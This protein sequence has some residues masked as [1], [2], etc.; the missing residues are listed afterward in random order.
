[1]KDDGVRCA[2]KQY[3]ADL[4]KKG[5]IREPEKRPE[6]KRRYNKKSECGDNV[7]NQVINTAQPPAQD[8][9]TF[10]PAEPKARPQAP[11]QVGF[12]PPPPKAPKGSYKE[13]SMFSAMEADPFYQRNPA[14]LAE[15][16]KNILSAIESKPADRPEFGRTASVKPVRPMQSD[17]QAPSV[18]RVI[19]GPEITG[20]EQPR[21]PV[22]DP[23]G[24]PDRLP[25]DREHDIQTDVA[26][27]GDEVPGRK[28]DMD[29]PRELQGPVGIQETETPGMR[30]FYD[31]LVTEAPFEGTSDSLDLLEALYPQ[32]PPDDIADEV[33]TYFANPMWHPQHQE[34]V[35]DYQRRLNEVYEGIE[36]EDPDYVQEDEN[37]LIQQKVSGDAFEGYLDIILNN[38]VAEYAQLNAEAEDISLQILEDVLK[39]AFAPP[40]PY[41]PA[42]ERTGMVE[43][44][45]PPPP[46]TPRDLTPLFKMIHDKVKKAKELAK[47]KRRSD[48]VGARK[49]APSLLEDVTDS[50]LRDVV[51]EALDEKVK[52]LDLDFVRAANEAAERMLEPRVASRSKQKI[53]ERARQARGKTRA[54][55]IKEILAPYQ[56]RKEARAEADR[57]R[58]LYAPMPP[59]ELSDALYRYRTGVTKE[60]VRGPAAQ[61]PLPM[62]VDDDEDIQG[63]G[64]KDTG[65]V[66]TLLAAILNVL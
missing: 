47:M 34:M 19:K 65:K 26:Q 61:V 43:R 12:T 23:A 32:G 18:E 14:L 44:P 45:I 2:Y 20:E 48:R 35:Q 42:P 13:P 49:T 40:V 28:E 7:I 60:G 27:V 6:P 41:G 36:R 29:S 37:P 59:Y 21:L 8:K 33:R 64:L 25:F 30:Q 16:K 57:R 62:D 66:K 52:D 46:V 55:R 9:P 56:A 24:M 31:E 10:S 5:I 22:F 63:S 38:A 4:C 11:A 50:E 58:R 39:E 54:Q 3:E 1:M 51:R 15:A 17:E 53:A